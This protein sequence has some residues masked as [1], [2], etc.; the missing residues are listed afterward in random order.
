[1]L[2]NMSKI[3]EESVAVQQLKAAKPIYVNTPV[4]GTHDPKSDMAKAITW[5][6]PNCGMETYKSDSS[7]Y[8]GERKSTPIQCGACGARYV[9]QVVTSVTRDLGYGEKWNV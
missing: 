3:V 6:C 4:M 5:K 7:H 2:D 1:M 8:A 9:M